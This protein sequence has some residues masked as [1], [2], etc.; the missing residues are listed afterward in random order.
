MVGEALLLLADVELLD[1]VYH[2]LLQAVLVV[3]HVGNGGQPFHD[4]LPYLLHA[5][6]LVGLDAGQQSGDVVQLLIELLLQ[7][8][9]LLPA[10][11]HE[12]VDGLLHDVA[13]HLPLLFR[14]F[15]QHLSARKHVRHADQRAPIVVRLGNVILRRDVQHL[16]VVGSHQS[17][18]DGTGI[19]LVLLFCPEVELHLSALQ[20]LRYHG[21]HL[22]FLL[23]I[24]G[25]HARRKVEGL[26]VE[27]LHLCY[28]LLPLKFGRGFA[29]SSHR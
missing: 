8:L 19:G 4:A 17:G 18:I 11:R 13:S 5:L 22:H 10:E 6:L 23:A 1:V 21:P 7:S 14:K 27:R 2:L 25:R 20:S 28:N 26:A 24:D 29:V 15:L 12:L 16:T 9:A 3:L